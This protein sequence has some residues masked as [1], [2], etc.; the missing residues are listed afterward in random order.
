VFEIALNVFRA[1]AEG[2]E[3]KISLLHP[4]YLTWFLM[5]L[6]IWRLT[7]PLW[8]QVRHPFLLSTAIAALASIDP[9][10]GPDLGLQRVLQFLPFFVLGLKMRPEHFTRLRERRVRIAAVP[11]LAG[12]ALVA[13]WAV[14]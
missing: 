14:L 6:F 1:W 4:W 10:I 8:Q 13:Y 7:A 12:G 11:V 3:L 5:A 2:E 9:W